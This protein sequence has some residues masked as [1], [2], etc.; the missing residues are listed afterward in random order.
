MK[1]KLLR[2]FFKKFNNISILYR[3]NLIAEILDMYAKIFFI[4]I[5]K[6]PIF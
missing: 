5:N 4:I 3:K 1:L 6:I 2:F